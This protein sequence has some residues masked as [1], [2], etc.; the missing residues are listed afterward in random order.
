[1]TIIRVPA[2]TSNLGPGFD[3]HGLALNLHLTIEVQ[4]TSERSVSIFFEGEGA[5]ELQSASEENLILRA[6]RIAAER[7]QVE[8]RP[9]LL[10]VKN[11]IPLARGLG[12]SGAAI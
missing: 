8:P 11:E 12:S 2:S 6:M 7:E 9:A 5:D 3:A 10:R 1:M 4:P